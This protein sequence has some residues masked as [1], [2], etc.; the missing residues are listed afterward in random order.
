VIDMKSMIV[1]LA[2][3]VPL[4]AS[5]ADE[6]FSALTPQQVA[7]KLKEK[8]VFVFDNNAPDVYKSAHVPKAKWLHPSEYD[9]KEL[10][11]D[12][13]ATLIFYCHNEH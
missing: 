8:N 12:K 5:A 6:Q 11:A 9:A 13:N 4:V 7:A 2:V 3:C 1:A 10:P